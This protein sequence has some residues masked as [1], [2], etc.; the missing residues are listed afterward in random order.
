MPLSQ[1]IEDMPEH[2]N[3]SE[4]IKKFFTNCEIKI[5]KLVRIFELFEHLC[6]EQIIDNLLDE[7]MKQIDENKKKLIDKYFKE[8]N[9]K[10][11]FIKKIEL[12]SAIRKF[13]S[14]Y[15]AGKRSQSEINEDKMLFDYLNRV[16]L[17][18][19]NIDDPNFETEYFK[20]SKLKIT[21]GEGYHFYKLLGGDSQL[22]N[23]N[24][25]YKNIEKKNNIEIEENI[26]NF[27]NKNII[28]LNED[29][30]EDEEEEINTNRKKKTKYDDEDDKDDDERNNEDSQKKKQRRKLF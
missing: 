3:I 30:D 14:R 23:L 17:W 16:D 20:L 18:E 13:I 2:I 15:L 26:D 9:D 29:E 28:N 25:E 19:R 10:N 22:L 12:A 7:F 8:N 5:N 21:V 6:W 1:I 11:N 27:E 24:I 4:N